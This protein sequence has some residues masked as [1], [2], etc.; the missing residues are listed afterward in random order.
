MQAFISEIGAWS[1]IIFGMLLIILE[2]VLPGAFLV[3]FGGAAIVT[4]IIAVVFPVSLP[5]QFFI[6]GLS[7]AVSIYL[8]RQYATTANVETDRPNLNIRGQHYVG[9]SF[10]LDAPIENGKGRMKVGDGVWAV[11]GPDVEAGALVRVTGVEGATLVVERA[12]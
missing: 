2:A 8:G 4:G 10:R 3:W 11:T 12:E 5:Y 9:Q 7:A 6:F 1:W